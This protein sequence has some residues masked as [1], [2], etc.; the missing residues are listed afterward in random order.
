MLIKI[1]TRVHNEEYFMKTFLDYYLGLEVDEIH[2]YDSFSTDKTDKI[3]NTYIKKSKPIIKINLKKDYLHRDYFEQDR[4]CNEILNYAI[5]DFQESKKETW[6]IFPDIDEF[7]RI[8]NNRKIKDHFLRIKDICVRFL[9]IDWFLSPDLMYK[10]TITAK[11][12]LDLIYNKKLKGE[13]L[14]LWND[15]FYKYY[16]IKLDTGVL[17]KYNK[18]KT[19]SGFHRFIVRNEILYPSDN[20]ILIVDHLRGI[21]YPKLKLRIDD[22]KELLKNQSD[23]WVLEHFKLVEEKVRQYKEGVLDKQLLTFYQLEKNKNRLTEFSE[24]DSI[25]DRII[26][27]DFLRDPLDFRPSKYRN[28]DFNKRHNWKR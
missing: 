4:L 19:L 25:F 11:K 23:D 6:W 20:S 26:T 28:Y 5:A 16:A 1:A 21:P 15:P 22:R 17:S 13:Y 10:D 7:I 2:I 8:P 27:Q 24:N 9:F 3:I 12:F 14:F 18:I